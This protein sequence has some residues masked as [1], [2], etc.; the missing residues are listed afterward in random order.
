MFE[1]KKE[2]LEYIKQ[3][4]EK[5]DFKGTRSTVMTRKAKKK[6]K[7]YSINSPFDLQDIYEN[8]TTK[9]T[10]YVIIRDPDNF[11]KDVIIKYLKI[12]RF[13]T[14]NHLLPY[15]M[16]SLNRYSDKFYFVM[17]VYSGKPETDSHPYDEF[18]KGVKLKDDYSAYLGGGDLIHLEEVLKEVIEARK[19]DK[20]VMEVKMAN[21]SDYKI[22]QEAFEPVEPVENQEE[23]VTA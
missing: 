10:D 23:T 13:K 11:D 1:G 20:T 15:M 16:Q 8:G 3:T 21:L 12:E 19:E 6:E 7:V 2:V 4:L 22:S 5:A 17:M 9:I 14:F 18:L